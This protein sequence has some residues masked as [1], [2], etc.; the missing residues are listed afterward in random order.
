MMSLQHVICTFIRCEGD[1]DSFKRELPF[2]VLPDAIR[3][4]LGTRV[5]SHFEVN[6]EQTDVS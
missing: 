4:Y 3:A 5:L 6:P 1:M 2:A